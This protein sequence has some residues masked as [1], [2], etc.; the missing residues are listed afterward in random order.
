M[1][2]HEGS[3]AVPAHMPYLLT[4][5]THNVSVASTTTTATTTRT[6]TKDTITLHSVGLWACPSKMPRYVAQVTDGVVGAVSANVTCLPTVVAC[7]VIGAV[8][9][10]VTL[11]IAVVAQ[12]QVPWWKRSCSTVPR[13]M[14]WLPTRVAYSL[15]RA[16]AC[17]VS[18]L[19]TVPAHG[20]CG[21]LWSNMPIQVQAYTLSG[22][23]I[24]VNVKIT[25][26]LLHSSL[27][28][29]SSNSH[30][31]NFNFSTPRWLYSSTES[32]GT[33]FLT[34]EVRNCDKLPH[35]GIL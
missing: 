19:S 15:I 13:S 8:S 14:P 4:V 7:L 28:N 34:Q 25:F 33:T 24:R 32:K 1:A 11:L 16:T 17:H 20:F 23:I 9:C 21:A 35:W 22:R 2:D 29:A 31:L 10:N 27:S 18:W 12:P 6:P 26:L 5:P 3:H 30:M